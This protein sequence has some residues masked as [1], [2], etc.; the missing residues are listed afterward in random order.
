MLEAH[1][2]SIALSNHAGLDLRIPT[3][4]LAIK[5]SASGMID[6]ERSACAA[7]ERVAA[8]R[9]EHRSTTYFFSTEASSLTVSITPISIIYS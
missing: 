3:D 9:S 2:N 1:I 8:T 7:I 4:G 6:I 5:H